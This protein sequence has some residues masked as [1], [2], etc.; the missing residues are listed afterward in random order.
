MPIIVSFDSMIADVGVAILGTGFI[1]RVHAKA[2]RSNG[3]RVV[4]VAASTPAR[5]RDACAELGAD[6]AA[7]A[8]ELVVAPDI[9]IVHIATPNHLHESLAVAALEAGKHVI[10]EKPLA[11][12]TAGAQRIADAAASA[13]RVVAVPFVYRFHPVVRQA[14]AMVERGDL[15]PVRLLHGSYQQDWMSSAEDWSWRVD[16][17]VGGPS[18]AFADIGSHWCDLVE[19]VTGHRIAKVF[20]HLTTAIE[21]RSAGSR[22]AFSVSSSVEGSDHAER[23][24][25]STEDV[26]MVLFQTDHDVPGSVVVSQISPGRKNRLW[27]EIDGEASSIVFDQ[28]DSEHLWLGARGSATTITRDPTTMVDDASRLVTMP[29]GHAQ[30]YQDCFDNFVADAYAAMSGDV[31][32]GLP[33][34][35]DGVRATRITDA[36]L[37]SASTNTWEDVRT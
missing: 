1:G 21:E 2:A 22:D 4:G 10:C 16:P 14:R 31:R 8:E 29:A 7:E 30:G 33:L 36:V 27:L 17:D 35:A 9:D 23:R 11:F 13:G 18:R 25:V 6:R 26:A 28:E 19:F 12:D 15:G 20:A 34:V 37:A 32:P 24:A 5:A 3:A